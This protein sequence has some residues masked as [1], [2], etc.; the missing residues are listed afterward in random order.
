MTYCDFEAAWNRSL[1]QRQI[2]MNGCD[3]LARY[4]RAVWQRNNLLKLND[5]LS[6]EMNEKLTKIL[7]EKQDN[8]PHG[9]G[10]YSFIIEM[11]VEAQHILKRLFIY[12]VHR[13]RNV[14]IPKFNM[15]V[16]G[17]KVFNWI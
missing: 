15:N 4:A 12:M 11:V 7:I 13:E 10:I 5:S 17:V 14:D 6:L 1:N 8:K 3:R 16:V 9:L 2:K